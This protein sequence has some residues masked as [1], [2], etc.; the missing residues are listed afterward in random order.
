MKLDIPNIDVRAE[1][2]TALANLK[3][4]K[5][6]ENK[7]ALLELLENYNLEIKNSKIVPKDK[8]E[9]SDYVLFWNQRQQARKILLN[10]L[11]GALLNESMKFYDKRIGQSV[12]LTGRSVTKHMSSETNRLITGKYEIGDSVVYSDTDSVTGD[13]KIRHHSGP[14]VSESTIEELFN[15][16]ILKWQ[17]GDKE[18]AHDHRFMVDG[19]NGEVYQ[20]NFNYIYRHKT[21]KEIFEITDELGN[22]V[23]VTEDHSCMV[24][25]DGILIEVKPSQ[26]LENDLIISI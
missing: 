23:K 24:E 12:T 25:R 18:Y 22:T 7:K 13:T 14:E 5:S 11:Y 16:A 9:Y 19:Y 2:N 3:V 10:S 26:I 21:E 15:S 8:S 1:I 17:N 4:T 20:T 6:E